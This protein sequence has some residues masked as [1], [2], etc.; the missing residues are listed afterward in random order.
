M[1]NEKCKLMIF[2]EVHFKVNENSM[3]YKIKNLLLEIKKKFE[4]IKTEKLDLFT[5][6]EN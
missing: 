4:F 1:E 2:N 6:K 5:K 3:Y